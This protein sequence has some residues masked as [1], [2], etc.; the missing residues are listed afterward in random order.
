M[1]MPDK[2]PLENLPADPPVA[3]GQIEYLFEGFVHSSR[4]LRLSKTPEDWTVIVTAHKLILAHMLKQLEQG[5]E[6]K[7]PAHAALIDRLSMVV[8]ALTVEQDM[9]ERLMGHLA[10]FREGAF[11]TVPA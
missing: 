3:W 2:N 8:E 10:T 1:S 11:Q 9:F 7:H 4:G 6:E 5:L